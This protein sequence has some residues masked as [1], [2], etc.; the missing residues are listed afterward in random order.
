MERGYKLY[1]FNELKPGDHLCILYETD[2]E[3]KA[4]ITY[5]RSGLEK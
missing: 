1:K 4:L 3:H 5:L 2:E